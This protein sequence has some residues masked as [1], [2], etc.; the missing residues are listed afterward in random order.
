LFAA[1]GATVS[2]GAREVPRGEAV[3]EEILQAGGLAAFFKT[4]VRDRNTLSAFITQTVERFGGIDIAVSNA[5]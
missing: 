2:I 1:E 5:E 4:D 3:V